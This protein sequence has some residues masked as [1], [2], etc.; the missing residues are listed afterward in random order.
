MKEIKKFL[1]MAL[2]LTAGVLAGCSE[3]E[4]EPGAKVDGTEV[5][6][7]NT[8]ASEYAVG[9]DESFV[10]V[11]VRRVKTDAA[12]TV[13]ILASDESKLFTIPASVTFGSGSDK[14]DLIIT[15]DRSKLVDGTEYPI[16]LL[17]TDEENT[18]PYGNNMITFTITPWPWEELGV[19][20]Y[21]DDWFTAMWGGDNIEVDVTIHKH[22]S[23]E[24]VYMVEEMFGWPFLT[25]FFGGTEDQIVGAGYV[26]YTPTNITID[27]SDPNKVYLPQQFSGVTDLDASYGDYVIAQIEG[28]WGTFADGI[29]T[30]PT[31]GLA[32]FCDAGGWYAN[33]SG[34][35]RIM[36]PGVE[37]A[38]YSLTAKYDGMKV[39]ADNETAK[40]V[41]NFTYGADVTG[42]SYILASGDVTSVADQIAAEMVA[43][44]IENIYAVSDFVAGGENLS[45]GVEFAA[46]GN[47]TIVAL[48]ADKEGKLVA[49]EAAAT[50]FYFPGMGGSAI[51]DCD[52]HAVLGSV[53]ENMP[54]K[55]E[56]YPDE[57]AMYFEVQGSELKTLQVLFAPT[58]SIEAE[59]ANGATYEDLADAYGE[60]YTTKW[61]PEINETGSYSSLWINLNADMSYTMIVKATNTYGKKAVVTA[62]CSTAVPDYSFYTGELAIGKYFMTFQSG[63]TT[64]ANTFSVLPVEGS[65]TDFIVQDLGM[66]NS[67][68]WYATYDSASSKLTVDGIEV[69]YEEYGNQFGAGYGYWDAAK[70]M[71]FGFYSYASE[72]SYGDDPC[73]FTVDPSTKEVATLDVMF[74]VPVYDASTYEVYGYGGYF[75]AG[76]AVSM[77]KSYVSGSSL[78]LSLRP[79][80]VPFSS[81]IVP[82]SSKAPLRSRFAT[83]SL[84]KN[85]AKP[86]G[87]RTLEVETGRCE[88]I[89]K[90]INGPVRIKAQKVDRPVM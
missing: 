68:S 63:E 72:E 88:P 78:L 22:K 66:D 89:D 81:V 9:D 34:L 74:A 8:I 76:T 70:T 87:V 3:E 65:T 4:Y 50:T 28:A 46:A 17:I 45:I 27:C 32:L 79:V 64:F 39:E 83:H 12:Q 80:R 14:A 85:L 5:Y 49:A 10:T 11:P 18:S 15:F 30:F 53:T 6:F 84:G 38:D 86:A 52:I 33:T 75:P 69:G 43:G 1:V 58:S 2:A 57:A 7:P 60:D 71:I 21:R 48:P 25:E 42:I 51:P 40:A 59:I 35:F 61:L 24:G 56:E 77:E 31:K 20:K 47:Y 29:I 13:T 26:T 37:A 36:L 16:S 67:T 82:S 44:N 55:A 90:G 19:G 62:T 73:V 41:I 23:K 54:D